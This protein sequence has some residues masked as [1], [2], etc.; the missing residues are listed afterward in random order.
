MRNNVH[1]S[2]LIMHYVICAFSE[3]CTRN[4]KILIIIMTII[5]CRIQQFL[6][7][8]GF[9]TSIARLGDNERRR[10]LT[11]E[12]NAFESLGVSVWDPKPLYRLRHYSGY[13]TVIMA[14]I[15]AKNLPAQ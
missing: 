4:M 3:A 10:K 2:M 1:E 7:G 13:G 14:I 12:I 5:Q 9:S 6:R 15:I 8:A 11:P